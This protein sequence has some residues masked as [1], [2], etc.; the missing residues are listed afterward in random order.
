MFLP[1]LSVYHPFHLP[2]VLKEQA[3]TQKCSWTAKNFCLW[4]VIEGLNFS[5]VWQNHRPLSLFIAVTSQFLVLYT[6]SCVGKETL[7]YSRSTFTHSLRLVSPVMLTKISMTGQ[8]ACWDL[9]IHDCWCCLIIFYTLLI[10]LDPSTTSCLL[11]QGCPNREARLSAAAI[12]IDSYSTLTP[13]VNPLQSRFTADIRVANCK[14]I[15][16]S[17]PPK[18]TV[19]LKC[20]NLL[21]LEWARQPSVHSA[22]TPARGQ[23]RVWISAQKHS[24]ISVKW[25]AFSQLQ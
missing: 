6:F 11:F 1:V 16:I 23:A 18:S 21:N 12:C 17:P 10:C 2:A 22:Y 25:A 9:A 15:S 24:K 14:Q 7:Q 13:H 3:R 4:Y 20:F 19:P 5:S 8:L